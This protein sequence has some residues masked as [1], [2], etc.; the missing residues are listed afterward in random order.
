ML[1]IKQYQPWHE[2]DLINAF[3]QDPDWDEFTNEST[4]SSYKTAL[5]KGITYVC[6][7][8][9]EFCG[10]IRAI[11][12]EDVAIYISE[13]YVVPEWRNQR[14]GQSLIERVLND[15]SAMDIYALSDE[16]AYYEKKGYSKAG[17][18]FKIE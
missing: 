7:V 11:P 16:D 9:S 12:D 10:F 2:G 13:L 1:A 5:H 4:V 6:Y 8:E 14:I 3:G 18:V 15:Y 17:S